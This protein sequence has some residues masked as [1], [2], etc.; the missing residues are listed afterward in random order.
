MKTNQ[1]MRNIILLSTKMFAYANVHFL[2]IFGSNC[3][4]YKLIYDHKNK[5]QEISL[6]LLHMYYTCL[7]SVDIYNCKKNRF[8]KSYSHFKENVVWLSLCLM[9][10][11]GNTKTL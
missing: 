10:Y 8:F 6:S 1:S 3:T 5:S 11:V 7:Y 2:I 4:R 9:A